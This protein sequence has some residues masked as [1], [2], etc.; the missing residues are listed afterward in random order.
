MPGIL[1]Q[2]GNKMVNCHLSKVKH[3]HL[4]CLLRHQHKG[5]NNL[6]LAPQHSVSRLWHEGWF[7]ASLFV[8]ETWVECSVPT[9]QTVISSLRGRKGT[10]VW[11][12]AHVNLEVV[13]KKTT[14]QPLTSSKNA[15]LF[16]P[17][18]LTHPGNISRSDL[19][20]D[21]KDCIL[22]SLVQTISLPLP[23]YIQPY[24]L[25][26]FCALKNNFRN[27]M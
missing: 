26:L 13:G 23:S 20:L 14:L 6:P 3:T 7:K 25:D 9:L 4:Y 11:P 8:L 24:F 5:K 1:L 19:K 12:R 2:S 22:T 18:S 16:S 17:S 15:P 27:K 10:W 21:C